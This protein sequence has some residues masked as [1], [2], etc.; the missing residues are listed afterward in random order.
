M[1]EAFTTIALIFV[2]I[3]STYTYDK[4]LEKLAQKREDKKQR[5]LLSETDKSMLSAR[6]PQIAPNI[7]VV[8]EKMT[9]HN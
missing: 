4:F 9:K 7:D 6:P 5:L 8:E 2:P 1:W 3:I